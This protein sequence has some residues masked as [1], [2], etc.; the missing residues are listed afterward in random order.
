M[1]GVHSVRPD[2][3]HSLLVK[4]VPTASGL[5]TAEILVRHVMLVFVSDELEQH[6]S[7]LSSRLKVACHAELP[8]GRAPQRRKVSLSTFAS[9]NSV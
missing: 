3:S 7:E 5:S 2:K 4:I 8:V 9:M 6:F 1:G